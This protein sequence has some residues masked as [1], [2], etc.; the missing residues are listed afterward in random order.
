MW[1]TLSPGGKVT[2]NRG[3]QKRKCF[4]S[5]RESGNSSGGSGLRL[6]FEI[7]FVK[8]ESSALSSASGGQPEQKP[9]RASR[10]RHGSPQLQ[11]KRGREQPYRNLSHTKCLNMKFKSAVATYEANVLSEVSQCRR[12]NLLAECV[13]RQGRDWTVRKSQSVFYNTD[14][15][16]N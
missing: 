16:N 5:W 4:L 10:I 13:R 15:V 7:R 11:R 12:A 1:D 3:C 8:S 2:K 9:S 6:V 14:Q